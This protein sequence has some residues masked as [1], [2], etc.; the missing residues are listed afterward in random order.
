LY[1][2][3]VLSQIPGHAFHPQYGH[4]RVYVKHRKDYRAI[5]NTVERYFPDLPAVYIVADIC[6]DDLLVE[7]EG[8][9]VLE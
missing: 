4:S 1:S 8:K 2:D 7:I 9:V 3:E 6:R 5:K